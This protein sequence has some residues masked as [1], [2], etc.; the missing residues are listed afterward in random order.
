[1]KSHIATAKRR[2]I[3]DCI[4]Y[5]AS[6][7]QL[8][9]KTLATMIG[10]PYGKFL[11]WRKRLQAGS[12]TASATTRVIPK[13]HWLLPAEIAAIVRYCV[14]NPGHGYRRLTWMMTDADVA[15]ASPSSV[16]RV[17]KRHGMLQTQEGKESRKGKGFDQP[18]APHQHWHIDFSY[19]KIG[20]VFYYFMSVVDG[21][22]RAVL[23]WDL[24]E[25][26]EER[27][28]EIVIQ[29]AREAYPEATCPRIISDRGAQFSGNDFK[30]FVSDIEATHVMT[31]PYYPQS[32]GKI[33]RF[34]RTLKKPA[35]EKLP[36]DLDDGKRIIG[37]LIDYYNGE[38]LHS[39]IGY[40][41]PHQCLAGAKEYILRERRSK[42]QQAAQ[43]RREHWNRQRNDSENRSDE[44]PAG[45]AING[46][47]IL[48]KP[49]PSDP[50]K[51]LEEA[52]KARAEER[53]IKEYS[54]QATAEAAS[55]K[56]D[57]K[58]GATSAPG[59]STPQP[60]A[61]HCL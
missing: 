17:L 7:T 34:H 3:V 10:L 30:S 48:P 50:L 53:A 49:R 36:L 16:Y 41:T 32:N 59:S 27:D 44:F 29:R 9:V 26:M 42:H 39:A 46:T 60:L 11:R 55:A 5:W 15:Y 18:S 33:E 21:Y 61:N 57:R 43:K 23:A 25:K 52:E 37:E 54:S 38:R 13:S 24:R 8:T 31:S 12:D 51:V 28:A 58:P 22:S 47:E 20:G 56:T 2:E 4:G 45:N 1:M 19:F 6:Q 35:Y 14:E 40:V